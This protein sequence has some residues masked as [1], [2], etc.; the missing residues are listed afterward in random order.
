M[1]PASTGRT[2]RCR[3]TAGI[4]GVVDTNYHLRVPRERR[5]LHECS[6]LP[7]LSSGLNLPDARQGKTIRPGRPEA[8]ALVRQQLLLGGQPTGVAREL[9]GAADDPVARHHDADRVAPVG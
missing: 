4:S 9:P 1:R 8:G 3:A 7:L 6:V 5:W 2:E